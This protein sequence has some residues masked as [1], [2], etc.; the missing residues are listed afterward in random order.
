MATEID[1][2]AER[3]WLHIVVTAVRAIVTASVLVALYYVLPL[4]DLSGTSTVAGLAIGIVIF[5]CLVAWQVWAILRSAHP[6]T[7]ALQALVIVLPLF[8]LLFASAYYVMSRAAPSDFSETLTRSDALYLTV[9]IFSTVGFGDVS[10][11][12]ETAR[13]VVTAQMI[14][15][16]IFLGVG[17]RVILGA[18]QRSKNRSADQVTDEEASSP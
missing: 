3:T 5:L 15:D 13:L 10:A 14:L 16:L 1:P 11:K 4:D 6:E 8:I 18:V 2:V 7:R 17:I 12:S 9:T